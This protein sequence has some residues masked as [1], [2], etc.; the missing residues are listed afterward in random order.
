MD[1]EAE[2]ILFQV[3]RILL[4]SPHDRHTDQANAV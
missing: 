4:W 2:A 1:S 3:S